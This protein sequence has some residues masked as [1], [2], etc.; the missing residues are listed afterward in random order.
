MQKSNTSKK[1]INNVKK[2]SKLHP[3]NINKEIEKSATESTRAREIEGGGG[4]N[5]VKTLVTKDN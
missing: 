5:T 3:Q 2:N 1:T 4:W